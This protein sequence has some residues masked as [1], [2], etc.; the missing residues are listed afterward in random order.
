[1]KELLEITGRSKPTIL[2]M[3]KNLESKSIIE[4]Y[5]TKL[6]DPYGVYKIKDSKKDNYIYEP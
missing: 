1:M 6:Y 3:I 4:W 2:K 5:G